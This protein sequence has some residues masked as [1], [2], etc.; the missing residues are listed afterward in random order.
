MFYVFAI[1]FSCRA[2][3]NSSVMMRSR[4]WRR[5]QSTRHSLAAQKFCRDS[6]SFKAQDLVI[7]QI[8]EVKIRGSDLLVQS[9][10]GFGSFTIGPLNCQRSETE[11]TLL[12]TV[13]GAVRAATSTLETVLS[14]GLVHLLQKG[15]AVKQYEI[16]A[17]QRPTHFPHDLQYESQTDK[18]TGTRC[19]AHAV[20]QTE[21][22][23]V[24]RDAI[25]LSCSASAKYELPK[26][27]RDTPELLGRW[28]PACPRIRKFKTQQ[29]VWWGLRHCHLT[30]TLQT[31]QHMCQEFICSSLRQS[32][33][34]AK[35]SNV[36]LVRG[37]AKSFRQLRLERD[38]P[39][40][41]AQIKLPNS[42]PSGS[43]TDGIQAPR[44]LK[45]SH[46]SVTNA[47]GL[48]LQLT[49]DRNNT[50]HHPGPTKEQ[51]A[52]DWEK[53]WFP[54]RVFKIKYWRLSFVAFTKGATRTLTMSSVI[55]PLTHESPRN[56]P[57]ESRIVTKSCIK[58]PSAIKTLCAV[59]LQERESSTIFQQ[60]A[61]VR[62]HHRTQKDSIQLVRATTRPSRAC[63]EQVFLW[64]CRRHIQI[65]VPER[66]WPRPG[67]SRP[68]DTLTEKRTPKQLRQMQVIAPKL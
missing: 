15:V 63:R 45:R 8:E 27:Q 13:S 66:D 48:F 60:R 18:Q 54:P 23:S 35:L 55:K 17:A 21:R 24:S 41:V 37:V 49:V 20:I 14:N 25:D 56:Q 6:T 53:W 52:V 43:T 50:Q 47:T 68:Q 42:S 59:A 10:Q 4:S 34:A 33:H 65:L 40:F 31:F 3:S 62:R 1:G 22:H 30:S 12:T 9:T 46:D 58:S 38:N 5:A 57:Y 64:P 67:L 2:A 32:Q 19:K 44:E 7:H 16:P 11:P 51:H 29:R 39:T 28:P 36:E 61:Y 26:D